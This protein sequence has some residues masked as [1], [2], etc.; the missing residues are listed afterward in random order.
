VP[1]PF[2][3]RRRA[4]GS[5]GRA[6]EGGATDAAANQLLLRLPA[7]SGFRLT[8][9][10]QPVQLER[11]HVLFRSDDAASVVVFPISA[12]VSLVARVE[13]GQTLEVGFIDRAGLVGGAA[14]TDIALPCDGIV[15]IGG[16]A[17]RMD[18][19]V[20]KQEVAADWSLAMAVERYSQLL[21][22]RCMQLSACNMFHS[23]EQRCARWLLTMKDVVDHHE[24]PLTHESLASML[25]VH[26]PTVTH[27]L[28]GLHRAGMIDEQRGRVTIANQ[29]A[30]EAVSCECY[31]RIRLAERRILGE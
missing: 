25:G 1:Q 19:A 10:L 17:L 13:S 20:F 15:Q 11:H 6:P 2:D 24:I 30:L 14:V 31:E 3:Q 4:A 23:A 28:G 5:S 9:H 29:A 8:P 16:S 26:R 7:P 27:V 12:V 18:A 22:T 21:L